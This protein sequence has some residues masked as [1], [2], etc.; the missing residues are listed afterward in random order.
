MKVIPLCK[1]TEKIKVCPYILSVSVIPHGLGL[2]NLIPIVHQDFED[3]TYENI[4]L[5]DSTE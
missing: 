2:F 3:T 1:M 4:Y 5:A